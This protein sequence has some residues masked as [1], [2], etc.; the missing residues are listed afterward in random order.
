VPVAHNAGQYWPRKGFVKRPGTINVI[1]GPPIVTEGRKAEEVNRAVQQWMD[2]AMRR[3]ESP[4][5]LLDLG[6][7][8]DIS[9]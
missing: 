1:I 8:R 3:I 5:Q 7:S 6:D 2:A 4:T 9:R